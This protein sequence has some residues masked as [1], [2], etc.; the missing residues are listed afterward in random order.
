MLYIRVIPNTPEYSASWLF[1]IRIFGQSGYSIR[2]S[3]IILFVN[4]PAYGIP[5]QDFGIRII[6][7]NRHGGTF[8]DGFCT[9]ALSG[10][11]GDDTSPTAPTDDAFPKPGT[12]AE[13]LF[14]R[15]ALAF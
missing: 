14:V 9:G 1:R 11:R 8:D 5:R 10:Y 4:Y 3:N 6:A 13:P 15:T 7:A 2:Y 12:I